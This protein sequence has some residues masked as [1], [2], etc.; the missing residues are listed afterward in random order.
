VLERVPP[1]EMDETLKAQILGEAR[2]IRAWF[3]FLQVIY[4]GNAPLVDHVLAPSEYGIGQSP[5]SEIWAFIER[6]LRK[7]YY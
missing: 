1:I 5:P 6:D 4:F 3:H 2:T 7:A